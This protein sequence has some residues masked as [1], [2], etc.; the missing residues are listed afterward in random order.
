A[1]FALGAG[2]AIGRRTETARL[3]PIPGPPASRG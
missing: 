3:V 2:V 1:L